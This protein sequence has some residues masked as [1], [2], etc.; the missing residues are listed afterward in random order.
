MIGTARIPEEMRRIQP[1]ELPRRVRLQPAVPAGHR[2][3]GDLDNE[4]PGKA[5]AL[6]QAEQLRKEKERLR[7]KIVSLKH[8]AEAQKKVH[9]VLQ[10]KVQKLREENELLSRGG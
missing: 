4:E 10:A 7:L 5:A 9:D 2:L 6:Q 3:R 1:G 8:S